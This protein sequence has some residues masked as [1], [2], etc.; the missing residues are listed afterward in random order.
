M[1]SGNGKNFCGG[2]DLSNFMPFAG[3]R[4]MQVKGAKFFGIDLLIPFCESFINCTKPLIAA[5]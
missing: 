4:E 5:V 3:D 1:L 2:N